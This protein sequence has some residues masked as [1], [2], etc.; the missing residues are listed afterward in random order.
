MAMDRHPYPW[1]F[2]GD[3]QSSLP[4][5]S[6]Q[7]RITHILLTAALYTAPVS[8]FQVGQHFCLRI[9]K[10]YTVFTYCNFMLFYSLDILM[11]GISF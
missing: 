6:V 8:N 1:M 7:D 10:M 4:Q 3:R 5:H 11:V 9:Y 2:T